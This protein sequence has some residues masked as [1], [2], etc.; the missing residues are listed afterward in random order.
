MTAEKKI[1]MLGI[2]ALDPKLCKKYLKEG[3]MP[4]LQ[5]FI[6]RGSARED[7]SLINGNPT[8]TPPMWTTLATGAYPVTHGITSFFRVSPDNL[9]GSGYNL[10]SSY[11]KA[12]QLWNVTAEA[13]LKT[14]VFH[15]PGSAWPPTSDS[16]NLH[17]V[18]GTQP[19][20]VNMG[21]A[22][23]DSEYIL[24]ASNQTSSILFKEKAAG[25]ANIPCVIEDLAVTDRKST[26][27]GSDC[28]MAP[29]NEILV[30]RPEDGEGG[31]PDA[32]FDV[33]YSPIKEAKG[34]KNAPEDAKEFV[35][36]F[37][38]G[39]VHR[40]V[41]LL[42]GESGVYDHIAIYKNKKTEEPIA[43]L[44]NNVFVESVIDEA[45]KSDK[46]YTVTRSMRILAIEPDG[47]KIKMWVSGAMNIHNDD[48][49]HPKH[50][51][52]SVVE[53]VGYP[54]PECMLGAGDKQIIVDCMIASWEAMM[55]WQEKSIKHLIQQENYN[56]VF[57]H[58]H[59]VDGCGHMIVHYM[60]NRENSK[61][62]EKVYQEC[63]ALVYEQADRY[64]G[65]F[66]PLLD[67]GWTI[68]LVSDHGQ[69]CSEYEAP[70]INDSCVSVR[71][72]EELGF[73]TLKKDENGND[74]YEI[75]WEH[76]KAVS[77]PCNIYINLK[78]R[79][80]HGIVEP[81]DKYALEDEIISALYNYRSK[82]TGKRVISLALRNRDAVVVGMGGPDCGDIVFFNAEGYTHDHADSLSTTLGYA[83]TSVCAT[84]VAAG[85]GIKENYT[86][87]R[88][89]RIADVVPTIAMMLG[90][91]YPAQCEG[92]PIYQILK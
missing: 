22:K 56:V 81:E 45:I 54:T 34:W 8:V 15:W 21:V 82:E 32:M 62:D 3:R 36:L 38:K 7:L 64:L 84:F 46:K 79:N 44:Q 1:M 5:K 66:I 70:M 18:D 40:D 2:D 50:L 12:E 51:Y 13:G 23:V 65:R 83:D 55:N 16:E 87:T 30:L 57:S 31:M 11:C 4:N 68:F 78:G 14:L 72:M 48:V 6:E 9:A 42:K 37:S 71:V 17:V 47:S 27:L 73:T 61:L 58:F 33:V 26:A 76:T 60:K 90:T 10:D 29:V 24:M 49:W 88:I 19:A 89:I 41:L 75:D 43:V 39:T 59:N 35:M 91:R 25:D 63:F 69:T 92:A 67:E 86:T 80:P 74:L 53:N 52:Q 77:H 20:A 85:T 28:V